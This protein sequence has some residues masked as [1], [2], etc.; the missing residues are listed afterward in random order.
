[1]VTRSQWLWTFFHWRLCIETQM[2]EVW[3]YDTDVSFALLLFPFHSVLM[4]SFFHLDCIK[5]H[6][7]VKDDLLDICE[8]TEKSSP[9]QFACISYQLSTFEFNSIRW[10]VHVFSRLSFFEK[11]RRNQ[12]TACSLGEMCIQHM[13][14]TT[15]NC[16][17]SECWDKLFWKSILFSNEADENRLKYLH[18]DKVRFIEWFV[19]I[20]AFEFRL[21]VLDCHCEYFKHSE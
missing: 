2:V 17:P 14:S 12:L 1:M 4:G 5:S 3:I 16:N 13:V 9:A 15:C 18:S 20:F 6:V 7:K 19:C 11:T 10:P 8:T 21:M